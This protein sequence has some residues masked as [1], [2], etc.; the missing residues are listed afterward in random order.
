MRGEVSEANGIINQ[1]ADLN[2]QIQG[3]TAAGRSPN[4]LLDSRENLVTELSRFVDLTVRTDPATNSLQVSLDGALLISSTRALQLGAQTDETGA[5]QLIIE[6]SRE[7]IRNPGGRIGSI[8][9]LGRD[10]LPGITEG[11]DTL[12]QGV[13]SEWNRIHSTATSNLTPQIV[14][15]VKRLFPLIS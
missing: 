13:M 14:L 3:E 9:E 2:L 4:D 7:L 5:P 12:A 15:S 1:I 8:V 11:L 10:I 6:D